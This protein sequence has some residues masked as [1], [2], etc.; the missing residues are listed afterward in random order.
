MITEKV[1]LSNDTY[2]RII[3]NDPILLSFFLDQG[4][5]IGKDRNLKGI[6]DKGHYYHRGSLSVKLY[7]N[8]DAGIPEGF[9]KDNK[10][11]KEGYKE[12]ISAGK[13]AK[14]VHMYHDISGNTYWISENEIIPEGFIKGSTDKQREAVS[15]AT[16]G[17]LTWNKGKKII[18]SAEHRAKINTS[19]ARKDVREKKHKS[20]L[21]K[22][23]YKIYISKNN[24]LTLCS[25]NMLDKYLETGWTLGNFLKRG[26][27]LS[28]EHKLKLSSAHTGKKIK[29]ETIQKII[30]TKRKNKTLNTSKEEII[31]Y[32]YLCKKYGKNNVF[33][34]YQDS[35]YSRY[36]KNPWVC[37]FYIKTID[38]FIELNLHW[39]H[40][41][42][43][44]DPNN[45]ND[46]MKLSEIRKKQKYYISSKGNLK[47][48]SYFTFERVWTITDPEKIKCAKKNNLNYM[49][50]YKFPE[51]CNI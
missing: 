35:R 29:Q 45:K 12:K 43:Q 3:F 27:P 15:K 1:T 8:I 24:T 39:T 5:K 21:G 23:K 6:R 33:K 37:D 42:H 13:K 48:N 19:Q 49:V 17:K 28:D 47:K 46:I 16:K 26:K 51:D 18:M 25:K 11:R 30:N 4:W 20:M 41:G 22:N 2:N 34:N 44:F 32:D 7:P 31:L 36:N 50:I 14:K 9:I 40:G 38:L 10:E